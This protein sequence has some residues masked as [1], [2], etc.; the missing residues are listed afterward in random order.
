MNKN[1]TIMT[2]AVSLVMT[3]ISLNANALPY[4]KG[5]AA[6]TVSTAADGFDYEG[7]S[8]FSVA[9]SV[10][11]EKAVA[12][13]TAAVATYPY[14]GAAD[15]LDSA[16]SYDP[17]KDKEDPTH[18]FRAAEWLI[19]GGVAVFGA[20][21]VNASWGKNLRENLRNTFSQKGQNKT[22]IDNYIQYAPAALTLGLGLCGVKGQHAFK[23]RA[24]IMM[25]SYATMAIVVNAA[26]YTFKEKRPDSSSRNSFPSGH[27]ATAFVGA[28]M[29]YQEYRTTHPWI[30]YT[31]YGL[32]AAVAYLRMHNDRHWANDVLAGAA[33]GMLST[34]FAYWLYPKIFREKKRENRMKRTAFFG[35]PYYQDRT[36]GVNMAMVF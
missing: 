17:Y 27:T 28:E 5:I 12:A 7:D 3:L 19:P 24:I 6:D 1:N 35:M 22:S 10:I 15:N 29:L 4:D 25:M 26:K 20:I 2:L 14:G 31:A 36:A 21:C 34:K 32:S 9:D 13:D 30:G 8:L 23:D 33:V 16:F 11:N 18:H